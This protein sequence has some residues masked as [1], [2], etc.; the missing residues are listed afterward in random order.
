MI[1]CF[2]RILKGCCDRL[3]RGERDDAGYAWGEGKAQ[4]W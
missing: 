3:V 1:F 2:D 4:L